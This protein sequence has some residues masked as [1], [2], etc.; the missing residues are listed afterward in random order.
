MVVGFGNSA[1]SLC[2]R[3]RGDLNHG[4]L[5]PVHG[6]Y[7]LSWKLNTMFKT[8]W[9]R[10]S[11]NPVVQPVIRFYTTVKGPE[12]NNSILCPEVPSGRNIWQMALIHITYDFGFMLVPH[13]FQELQNSRGLVGLW[14][15]AVALQPTVSFSSTAL[16]D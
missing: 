8:F 3:A 15:D 10:T 1:A 6:F 7:I 9:A 4:A 16:W 12:K 11:I 14:S 13:W 2:K 5:A